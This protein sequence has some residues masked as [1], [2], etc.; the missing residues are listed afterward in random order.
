MTRLK[1]LGAAAV[2]SVLT[3]TPVFAQATIHELGAD[4]TSAAARARTSEG[5]AMRG[6]EVA[7]PSWSAGCMTDQGPSPCGEPMWVYGS[8]SSALAR[9]KNAF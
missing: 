6:R 5:G 1:S 3:A 4:A 7:A 2:L 8:S 9:Y